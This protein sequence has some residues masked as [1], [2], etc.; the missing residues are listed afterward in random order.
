VLAYSRIDRTTGREFLVVANS[1][2]SA[3]TV[4][5]PVGASGTQYERIR[6][7]LQTAGV[8]QVTSD[9]HTVKL[10]VPPLSAMVYRSRSA[11]PAD[12]AAPKP[13]LALGGT[14]T[15]DGRQELVSTV[16]NTSYAQA[17]FA[18]RRRG[19]KA[20]TVLGTDDAP[21][22]RVFS[23]LPNGKAELRVVVKDRQ[24]RIGAASLLR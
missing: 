4:D 22:Y 9:D 16:P 21:P 19:E 1:A 7:A 13:T 3:K 5:V 20:W 14:T 12:T 2:T 8:T 17:T 24:N 15:Q 18:V 10:T 23:K 6:P 11:L